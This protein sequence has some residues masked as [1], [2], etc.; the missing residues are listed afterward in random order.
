M[1]MY[2]AVTF[3]E[4][5]SPFPNIF[6][7][8]QYISYSALGPGYSAGAMICIDGFRYIRERVIQR[9]FQMCEIEIELIIIIINIIC[10]LYQNYLL[11][12]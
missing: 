12:N 5:I 6:L 1:G 2:V 10:A 4:Y 11:N 3:Y 7:Y 9:S 8:I